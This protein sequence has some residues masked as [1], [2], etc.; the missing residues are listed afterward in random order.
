LLRQGQAIHD[1]FMGDGPQ[2]PPFVLGT[3]SVVR[4]AARAAH[5]EGFMEFPSDPA[6][7]NL[8]E[9]LPNDP[10]SLTV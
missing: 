8:F 2:D 3:S 7:A 4:D 5:G 1:S 9:I 6:R 10:N